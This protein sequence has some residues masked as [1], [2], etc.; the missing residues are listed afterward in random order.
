M[1]AA[2][3]IDIDRK[4]YQSQQIIKVRFG[5]NWQRKILTGRTESTELLD[6]PMIYMVSVTEYGSQVG[7]MVVYL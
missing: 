7:P 5:W 3:Y 1:N 2:E 4:R 6:K